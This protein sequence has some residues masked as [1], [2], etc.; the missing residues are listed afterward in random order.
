MS[1]RTIGPGRTVDILIRLTA[2]YYG[3][4]P[5]S[6]TGERRVSDIAEARH[7]AMFLSRKLTGLS[8]PALGRRFGGRDHTTVM[9][10]AKRIERFPADHRLREC[11]AVIQQSFEAA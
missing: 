9:A 5:E 2:D 10:A 3:V 8:Y 11:A 1:P 4:E 7:V 6:L